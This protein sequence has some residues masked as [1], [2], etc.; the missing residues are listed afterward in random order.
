MKEYNRRQFLAETNCRKQR[1]FM[2]LRISIICILLAAA[3]ALFACLSDTKPTEEVPASEVPGDSFVTVNGV[4]IKYLDWGGTGQA[5]VLIHGVDESP[6]AFD[7]L[8]AELRNDFR[9]IAYARRGH[10]HSDAPDGPYDNATLVEDLRQLLDSLGIAETNLLGWSMGGNEI[11]EF[12][13]RYPQ[14]TRKLVYLEAGYDWSDAAF[15]EALEVFPISFAP[16]STALQSLDMYRKWYQGIFTPGLAWTPGLEAN[17]RELTRIKP[18]GTVQVIPSAAVSEK[19]WASL[20]SYRRD[21]TAVRAPALALYSTNFFETNMP[22]PEAAQAITSWERQMMDPF[23][24]ASI[25]RIREELSGVIVREIPNIT[26][27]SIVHV[28]QESLAETI[29]NF[30]LET[31]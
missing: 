28:N 1:V 20:A 13:G 19:L 6:H 21:Y 23:R 17:I 2:T 29:R 25:M 30:L 12:A 10:A 31:Q 4:R 18:D 5:L 15:W 16:D 8:A 11:T 26:H 3:A 7:H 9:V 27:V 22:D 24:L 14:R